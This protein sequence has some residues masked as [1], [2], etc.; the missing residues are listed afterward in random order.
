MATKNVLGRVYEAGK[1]PS[2]P[3]KEEIVHLYTQG[4]ETG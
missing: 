4:L 2:L 3:V 1:S